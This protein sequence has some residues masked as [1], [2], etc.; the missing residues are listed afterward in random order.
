MKTT[1]TSIKDAEVE[2]IL[3]SDAAAIAILPRLPTSEKVKT[4]MISSEEDSP[5][6]SPTDDNVHY[7]DYPIRLAFY[8]VYKERDEAR[9]KEV[10]RVM[11]GDD[12]A[13]LLRD[14]NLFALPDTVRRKL[15]IDLDLGE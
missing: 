13:A 3:L 4:L 10:L 1:V 7:G 6:F 2:G 5:A 8:V 12:L 14:N 15:T 9:A 11:L